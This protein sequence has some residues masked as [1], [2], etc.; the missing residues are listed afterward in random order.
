MDFELEISIITFLPKPFTGNIHS[1]PLLGSLI[2]FQV[3]AA[4][5]NVG[6][7]FITCHF[8]YDPH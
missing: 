2:T 5:L 3:K 1:A 6:Q 8:L 7:P 4:D